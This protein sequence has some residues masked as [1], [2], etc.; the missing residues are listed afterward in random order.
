MQI[1]TIDFAVNV[2]KVKR[3]IIFCLYKIVNFF[4]PDKHIVIFFSNSTDLPLVL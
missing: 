2:G 1:G 4:Q 3:A